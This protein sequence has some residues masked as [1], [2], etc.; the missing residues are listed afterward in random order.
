VRVTTQRLSVNGV[1]LVYDE[2]G[3]G[4]RAF[5]LV[6]GFTG[7]RD[8]F[9]PRLPELAR[10]GRTIAYDQRGHGDSTKTGDAATYSFAQLADDLRA[11]VD[12]LGLGRFDL[13]GHS[14]GGM[15]ALRFVLANPERVASLVL[16]DT[17]SEPLTKRLPR[18]IFDAGA[19]IGR[20]AGMEKLLE[21]IR[22]NPNEQAV[23]TEADRRL[24]R[25]WGAERYA[26]HLRARLGRMDVEAFHRL[27]VELSEAEPMTPRLGEIR[28]PTLVLVGEQDAGFLKP[29]EVM[30]RAIPGARRVTLPAAGHSPQLEAP[31]AWLDAVS[32][33][34]RHARESGVSR[35]AGRPSAS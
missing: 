26:A 3:A 34:L 1:E 17:A 32:E 28:C 10:L 35:S 8:D 21:L 25:E 11:L 6:H 2:S 7:Y 14:M 13:L 5:V 19:K 15:V 29:A 12:A 16:M 20:E 27:G 18:Q 22:A 31:G 30:E 24:E 23:R 4:D 9:A 33:H